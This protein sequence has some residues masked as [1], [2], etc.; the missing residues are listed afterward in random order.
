MIIQFIIQTILAFSGVGLILGSLIYS[1]NAEVSYWAW[2]ELWLEGLEWSI[3]IL[4]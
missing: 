4:F 1:K 3:F 2:G